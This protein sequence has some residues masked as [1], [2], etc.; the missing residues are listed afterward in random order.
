VEVGELRRYY[1][2]TQAQILSEIN[3]GY[4]PILTS[5]GF[6]FCRANRC[7]SY[8]P[9][10]TG[11]LDAMPGQPVELRVS[12]RTEEDYVAT[13]RRGFA[14]SGDR[15][16]GVMEMPSSFP[17]AEI[18]SSASP[19][20]ASRTRDQENVSTRYPVDWTKPTTSVRSASRMALCSN[21]YNAV[22]ARMHLRKIIN[23]SVHLSRKAVSY[24]SK[25]LCPVLVLKTTLGA[26]VNA[27]LKRAER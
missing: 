8:A 17:P 7:C 3:F 23:A 27:S 24:L 13:S 4:Q 2:L 21:L 16:G 11:T 15:L 25:L 12:R 20:P 1:D 19:P 5:H 22:F 18:S 6:S 10:S 26:T 14:G 9:L